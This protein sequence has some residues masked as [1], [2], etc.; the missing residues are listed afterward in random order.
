MSGEYGN[1]QQKLPEIRPDS[2]SSQGQP[3]KKASTNISSPFHATQKPQADPDVRIRNVMNRGS[4]ETPSSAGRTRKGS[5]LKGRVKALRRNLSSVS[6]K[7]RSGGPEG[8]QQVPTDEEEH[9]AMSKS[10]EGTSSLARSAFKRE[11]VPLDRSFFKADKAL[12]PPPLAS[13]MQPCANAMHPSEY[14]KRA[15]VLPPSI[16]QA[17]DHRQKHYQNIT[18]KNASPT[19]QAASLLAGI[20]ANPKAKTVF[21][22]P[23]AEALMNNLLEARKQGS[24]PAQELKTQFDSLTKTPQ[25]KELLKASKSFRQAHQAVSKQLNA[26][27]GEPHQSELTAQQAAIHIGR[28]NLNMIDV[29]Q[30]SLQNLAVALGQEMRMLE[31]GTDTNAKQA[32]ANLMEFALKNLPQISADLSDAEKAALVSGILTLAKSAELQNVEGAD[33]LKAL[34]DHKFPATA[35]LIQEQPLLSLEEVEAK[36]TEAK[37]KALIS[38]T[39]QLIDKMTLSDGPEQ[40]ELRDAFILGGNIMKWGSGNLKGVNIFEQ[41]HI[42]YPSL[43]PLQQNNVLRL[44]SD[45]LNANA[46][47]PN[48]VVD[49]EQLKGHIQQLLNT[50]ESAGNIEDQTRSTLSNYVTSPS[51]GGDFLKMPPPS[52]KPITTLVEEAK[53]EVLG[54]RLNARQPNKIF[55]DMASL[56][57]D[58]FSNISLSELDQHDAKNSNPQLDKIVNLSKQITNLVRH[59]ILFGTGTSDSITAKNHIEIVT[60]NAIQVAERAVE[61]HHYEVGGAIISALGGELSRLT[62]EVK[63]S[64][65]AKATLQRLNT[66]Y[67]PTGGSR[68]L[69][70]AIA[71]AHEAGAVVF[72]ALPVVFGLLTAAT[73]GNATTIQGDEQNPTQVNSQR[74]LIYA[75]VKQSISNFV[76]GSHE[77]RKGT[78]DKNLLA[79][80]FEQLA[81]QDAKWGE[82]SKKSDIQY[83]RSLEIKPR[84]GK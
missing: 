25:V 58:A 65:E 62:N 49:Q 47:L 8:E 70:A 56:Y 36:I 9:E 28:G 76:G 71:S 39:R 72:P 46:S 5:G 74:L 55:E 21:V 63:L 81:L 24:A 17:M 37:Q 53:N 11:D 60:A 45:Y 64:D 40:K 20:Q 2:T 57:E 31:G 16:A 1:Y 80:T 7:T 52:H 48:S 83:A 43:K 38:S 15:A 66:L 61:A 79:D 4:P 84:G 68:N 14:T 33:R 59:E 73:E 30:H 3:V 69:R 82:E 22:R 6:K 42:I 23:L 44:V 12:P 50:A 51:K 41:F 26:S 54:Y 10:R 18:L 29:D 35:K 78:S 32:R 67:D 75:K 19:T 13:A 27:G 77:Q 34:V